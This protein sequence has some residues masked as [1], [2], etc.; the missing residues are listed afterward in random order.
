MHWNDFASLLQ[1]GG[2]G[3]YVWSSLA[4]TVLALAAEVVS[5]ALRESDQVRGEPPGHTS[6]SG[7]AR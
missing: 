6:P 1:M 4:A 2:H 5:L 3:P 7:P